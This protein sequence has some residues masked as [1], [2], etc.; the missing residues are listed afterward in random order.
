M[1][2]LF[3][4]DP[5]SV[6]ADVRRVARNGDYEMVALT[7]DAAVFQAAVNQVDQGGTLVLLSHGDAAGPL[8]VA[9]HGGDDM[10]AAQITAFGG[11]MARRDIS[12]Y[13]LSCYTGSGA[14]AA[15]MTA[16]GVSFI[17]PLGYAQLNAGVGGVTV[18]SV[19][20][21]AQ[22]VAGANAL[23]W[24]SNGIR[25]PGRAASPLSLP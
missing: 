10:T 18:Y 1:Q 15:R 4:Y 2:K 21:P 12:L 22:P 7:D 23:G 11:L 6:N 19:A 14:F 3:L 5:E 13:L 16:L 8:M 9:G 20:N 17:A 24:A 25:A